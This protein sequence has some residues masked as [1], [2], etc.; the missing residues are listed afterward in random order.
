MFHRTCKLIY[1]TFSYLGFDTMACWSWNPIQGGITWCHFTNKWHN[2]IPDRVV[3]YMYPMEFDA[4]FQRI[5]LL[6]HPITYVDTSIMNTW[7]HYLFTFKHRKMD[8]YFWYKRTLAFMLSRNVSK[9]PTLISTT[10]SCIS[11]SHRAELWVNRILT[12]WYAHIPCA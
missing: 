1:V 12:K 4:D 10:Q 3:I 8:T 7:K 5:W 6:L 9:S 11:I 2:F